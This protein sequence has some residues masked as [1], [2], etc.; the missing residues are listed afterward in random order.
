MG[1]DKS[2]LPAHAPFQDQSNLVDQN[3]EE[4]YRTNGLTF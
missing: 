1:E 4:P 3:P 2:W